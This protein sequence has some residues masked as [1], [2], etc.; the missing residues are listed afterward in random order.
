MPLVERSAD[1]WT[2]DAPQRFLGMPL[3]TRMTVVRLPGAELLLYS[4]VALGAA[5]RGNPRTS[6]A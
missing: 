1:L 6:R 2:L 5:E 3:G 4:P